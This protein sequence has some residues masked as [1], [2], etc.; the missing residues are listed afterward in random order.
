MNKRAALELSINAIVIIVIAITVLGLALTFVRNLFVQTT[1][2]S[3]EVIKGTDLSKLVNPPTRDNPL[4]ITP[5]SLEL[6]NNQQKIIGVAF[7][8]TDPSGKEFSLTIDYECDPST[9][10][11]CD[12]AS[13]SDCPS[14]GDRKIKFIYNSNP[15]TLQPDEIAYWKIAVNPNFGSTSNPFIND[16]IKIFTVKVSSTDNVKKADVV[17]T[18]K[19]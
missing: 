13:N 2:T 4:T 16:E 10:E 18:V 1:E 12:C 19:P 15:I 8:N 11:G 7:M 17:I 3:L 14:S 6:R 5:S 9:G